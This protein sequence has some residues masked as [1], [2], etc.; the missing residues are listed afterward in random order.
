MTFVCPATA[1]AAYNEQYSLQ[2]TMTLTPKQTRPE[3][4]S[5]KILQI[6]VLQQ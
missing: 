2:A 5:Y 3:D 1:E 6:L 4:T